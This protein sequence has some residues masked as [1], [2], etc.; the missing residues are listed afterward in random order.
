ML[1]AHLGSRPRRYEMR[2]QE[3]STFL[4]HTMSRVNP[5]P[6]ARLQQ[7]PWL[8]PDLTIGPIGLKETFLH[9]Q[10]PKVIAELRV[11]YGAEGKRRRRS[12][13]MCSYYLPL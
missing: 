8:I 4:A 7:V 3:I 6:I 11:V 2:I 5:L 10:M 13:S 12:K 1:P 9:S